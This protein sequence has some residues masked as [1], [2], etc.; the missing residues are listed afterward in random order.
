MC[1]CARARA[2]KIDFKL[3]VLNTIEFSQINQTS[4]S[5]QL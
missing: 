1:V 5:K 4:I 2:R 3:N